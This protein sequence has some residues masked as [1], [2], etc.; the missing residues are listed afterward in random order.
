MCKIYVI[1]ANLEQFSHK[2]NIYAEYLPQKIRKDYYS[3]QQLSFGKDTL[4]TFK[5]HTS[6]HKPNCTGRRKDC[7]HNLIVDNR[8]DII[9]FEKA[10]R[11]RGGWGIGIAGTQNKVGIFHFIYV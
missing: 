7:A 3:I 10:L 6:H 11:Y 5:I 9:A 2:Y 4:G 1:S 8:R